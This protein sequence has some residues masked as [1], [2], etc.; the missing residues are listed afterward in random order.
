MSDHRAGVGKEAISMIDSRDRIANGFRLLPVI[1][2]REAL[3][4][5]HV[6]HRVGLE[7][8]NLAVELLTRGIRFGLGE[9][10]GEDNHRAG[11]TLAHCAA[12]LDR[13]LEG[14]P[15][16]VDEAARN[17]LGPQQQHVHA[18]IGQ[19]VVSQGPCHAAHGVR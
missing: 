9:A 16:R 11:F 4:L 18:A 1:V 6:E 7:E 5:R 13:L 15:H 17:G 8:R 19:T 2:V 10:A 3:D 14:H 12:E